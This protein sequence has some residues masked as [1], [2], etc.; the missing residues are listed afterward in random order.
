MRARAGA[1]CPCVVR[2]TKSSISRN[3]VELLKQTLG[4]TGVDGSLYLACIMMY[5]YTYRQEVT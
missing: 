2:A 1:T 5:V 4:K 3:A